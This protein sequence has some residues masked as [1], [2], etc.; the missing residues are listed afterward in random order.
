MQP[1]RAAIRRRQTR[2]D[3][4]DK[5]K[6]AQGPAAAPSVLSAPRVRNGTFR[7]YLPPFIRSS[8]VS[9]N[10][11]VDYSCQLLPILWVTMC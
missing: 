8:P 5:G 11:E 3:A 4:E 6:V 2:M 7:S 1:Y 10:S 9:S